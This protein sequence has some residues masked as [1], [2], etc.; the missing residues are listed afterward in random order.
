MIVIA[1]IGVLAASL[2]PMMSNYMA[3]S[4]DTALMIQVKN[5]KRSIELY[6]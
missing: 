1:I 5:L 2:F 6:Q 4:R 3:R